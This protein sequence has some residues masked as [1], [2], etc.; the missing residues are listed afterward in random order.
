MDNPL[1]AGDSWR[2]P[3]G[4]KVLLLGE[5]GSGKTYSGLLAS[6]QSNRPIFVVMSEDGVATIMQEPKFKELLGKQIFVHYAP[7][8]PDDFGV[9]ENEFQRVNQMD[10]DNIQK[11]APQKD[12]TAY[13]S[14]YPGIMRNFVCQF[15]G[16]KF[17]NA[18][19]W[20]AEAILFFDGLSGLNEAAKRAVVG[21]RA[22]M[23]MNH[24]G[25]AMRMIEQF[26][27][28]FTLGLRCGRITTAHIARE[29]DE[30]S[31]GTK[32]YPD[33]LGKKLAPSIGKYFDQVIE[34]VRREGKYAWNTE[35]SML[36]LKTRGLPRGKGLPID[37]VKPGIFP[38]ITTEERDAI[39]EGME[40]KPS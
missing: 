17:G 16:R 9:L 23:G 4:Q 34:Q 8:V 40:I 1:N 15:S 12:K 7:P 37:F 11:V 25:V 33:T 13:L 24:W 21:S 30:I 5:Y 3:T 26:V 27:T 22:T 19:N 29:V 31:G 2:S 36:A 6:Y 18:K 38:R 14:L 28:S 35:N 39:L 10:V 20:P 32:L